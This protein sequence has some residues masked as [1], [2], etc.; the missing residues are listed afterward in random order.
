MQVV[1]QA[2]PIALPA[3]VTNADW[4][5]RGANPQHL[6]PHT[7][8]SPSFARVWSNDIGAGDSRRARITADPVFA[9]GRIFTLDAAAQV[10]ATSTSGDTLWSTDLVPANEAARDASG[11]GLALGGG[12]L[13]ATTGFGEL[14]ALDPASGAVIWVQD[15]DAAGGAAPTV[16]GDLVYVV[17]RDS[18]AWAVEAESGRIAWVLNGTPAS[19]GVDAAS[20]V[21]VNAD[22]AIFPFSSGE[23]LGTFPRG[24]FQVWN[25]I[26]S[27]ERLGLAAAQ[28]SDITGDPVIAGDRVF[29]GNP[30][31]RVLA[32]D[33][34][35]GARLWTADEGA[36]SPVL[37]VGGSVFLVNDV[38]QLVRLDAA[39]GARIWAVQLPRFIS[40]RQQSEVYAHYGPILAGGALVVAS[41]DGS[42]R[43]FDPVSGLLRHAADLPSGAASAPIVAGGTLYAVTSRGTL[44]AFR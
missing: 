30:T 14:V 10:A 22:F 1:N 17:A 25:T 3:P 28:F 11:G 8:L 19:S 23:V 24:G 9:N 31:G 32:L 37:P 6:I 39:T 38:A 15:L 13:F 34:E 4:T 5:H 21:A 42:L 12:R 33:L 27:G 44:E 26:V 2:L 36:L 18:R 40:A 20:S 7:A 35:T 43:A 29:V 16:L 41:S